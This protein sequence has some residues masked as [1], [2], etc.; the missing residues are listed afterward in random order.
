MELKRIDA[1][2][3]SKVL[4]LLY[5]GIGLLMGCLFSFFAIVG[6]VTGIG[7]HGADAVLPGFLFGVGAAVVLPVFYGVMGGIMGLLGAT[8]YNLTARLVGGI[9]VELR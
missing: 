2:S 9:R 5:A 3:C 8:L 7:A 6:T 1:L 4:A